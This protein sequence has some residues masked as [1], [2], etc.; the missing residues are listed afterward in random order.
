[1]ER[2][3]IR[4]NELT[5]PTKFQM[6]DGSVKQVGGTRGKKSTRKRFPQKSGDLSVRWCSSYLKIDVAKTAINNDDRFRKV[7]DP[8]LV[9]TL[10]ITGERA[11]ESAGRAKYKQLEPH[12]ADQRD[13]YSQKVARLVDHYRPVLYWDESEIWDIIKEYRVLVHPVYFLGISRVSCATCIFSSA[14]QW[15]T[16]AMINPSQVDQ[17]ISYEDQFQI[18]ID[19]KKSIREMIQA[20]TPHQTDPRAVSLALAGTYD[21]PIQIPAEDWKL[22]S[23]AFG[24]SCGPI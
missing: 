9:R 21:Q 15:A 16:L 10:V 13:H 22:P 4:E 20:G 11:Q 19:R 1:M 24:E 18:T 6:L 5:Q 7:E 3:L 2:E 17:V 23:G 12:K 8:G 14:N